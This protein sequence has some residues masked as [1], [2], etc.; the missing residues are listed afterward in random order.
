M[1]KQIIF[2]FILI[3]V[4]LAGCNAFNYGYT[5]RKAMN[6]YYLTA[7][8]SFGA[9]RLKYTNGYFRNTAFGTHLQKYGSPDMIYE[10]P[11]EKKYQ[12]IK[13]FYLKRDS[14]YVFGSKSSNCNCMSL[15]GSEKISP[16]E[17]NV[18]TQLSGTKSL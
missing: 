13:L 9:K 14:V 8:N 7:E 2:L 17:K 10:Y 11:I 16:L 12:G 5:N 1:P 4:T 6:N 3:S 15:T 18:Y